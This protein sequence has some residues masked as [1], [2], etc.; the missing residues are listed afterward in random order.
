MEELQVKIKWPYML[1]KSFTTAWLK[2][3]K[4]KGFYTDKISDGG[5]GIKKVDCYLRSDKS[6][7]CC[8][9]K[10]I[11]KDIFPVNRLRA[12]QFASLRKWDD[13]WWKAIVC[14]YSKEYNKYKLIPFS[15]I[16]DIDKNDSIKLEFKANKD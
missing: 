6:S 16:K 8:E 3:L 15:L 10:I 1:E 5:I 4:A 7:Y 14:V 12:N 13:L 11:A 9:I 2:S